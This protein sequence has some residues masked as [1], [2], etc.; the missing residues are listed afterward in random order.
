MWSKVG[1]KSQKT[2]KNQEGKGNTKKKRPKA[3]KFFQAE[4]C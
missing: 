4:Y 2:V 1:Q 3:G